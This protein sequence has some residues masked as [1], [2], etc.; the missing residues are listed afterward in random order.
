MEPAA[1]DTHARYARGRSD[2]HKWADGGPGRQTIATNKPGSRFARSAAGWHQGTRAEGSAPRDRRTNIDRKA[3]SPR[4]HGN[5][6]GR[7]DNGAACNGP[8]QDYRNKRSVWNIATEPTPEAHFATYPQ[9]LVRPCILAGC[10]KGGVVLDP[11]CGS[12]TTLLVAQKL[13]CRGIG[14]ELNPDYIRIAERRLAQT[15]MAL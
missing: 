4:I 11:F 15:V 10:P 7:S 2:D 6:P 13:Q 3:D 14:I 1:A 12:G 5:I 8:G 9:D